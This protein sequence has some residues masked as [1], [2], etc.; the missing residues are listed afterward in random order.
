MLKII[1]PR[2]LLSW[3][4]TF[5]GE[6]RS[7]PSVIIQIL[8]YIKDNEITLEDV[9]KKNEE[10]MNDRTKRFNGNGED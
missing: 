3:L 5:K 8:F 9:M 2:H 10:R 7:L 6:D 4:M 1:L